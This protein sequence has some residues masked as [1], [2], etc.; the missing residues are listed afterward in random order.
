L[1]LA[2]STTINAAKYVPLGSVYHRP[3]LVGSLLI[4]VHIKTRKLQSVSINSINISN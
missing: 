1:R 4:M 3:N 2:F